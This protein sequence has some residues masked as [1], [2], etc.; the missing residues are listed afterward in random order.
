VTEIDYYDRVNPDLLRLLP[1]DVRV[2]V[3]VGCGAGAL[4]ERYKRVN[5]HGRYFGIERHAEAARLAAGRLDG[6]VCGDVEQIDFAALGLAAGTVDC[7]VYGD[8]LEHLLDPWETLRR[9][10]TWLRPEGMVLAC[11]PNVQHWTIIRALLAGSWRYANEGLL[12][13]THL[14][15]FTLEGVEHLLAAAGLVAIDVR[16]REATGLPEEAFRDFQKLMGPVIEALGLDR[17]RFTAKTAA[18]QY[19]VRAGRRDV[20]LRRVLI[21]TLRTVRE[22][23]EVRVD[24]PNAF[25]ATLPGVRAITHDDRVDYAAAFA[26]E[27]RV[28]ILQ[29]AS[30]DASTGAAVVRQ[31]VRQGYLIVVEMDDDPLRWPHYADQQFFTFRACHAIQTSTELLADYFRQ[32]NPNVA[33]FPNQIASL[34]PPRSDDPD[35]PVTLFFG[36]LNRTDDW[37]P[38]MPALNRVLSDFRGRVRAQVVHDRGFFDA[39]QTDDKAFEP[40]CAYERYHELLLG[41]D[42]ALLP[43]NPTRFNSMKSDL[44]FIQCAAHGVVTLASPT[45]YEQTLRDGETGFLYR[46]GTEFEDRLRQ[47]LAEADLRRQVADRAYQ[48]VR[49]HRMLGQHFRR[50]H[51][52]YLELRGELPRLNAELRLRVPKL[53][54]DPQEDSNAFPIT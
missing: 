24:E 52:W 33:V 47:L 10:V 27:E 1:P 15:F 20:P 7:L 36:A 6:V 21:Q 19:V 9:Q 8:V 32:F 22:A 30:L 34:P 4:G 46:S 25:C 12:D 29:R 31:W 37:Q 40:W 44:K 39:L 3:D 48:Y 5:P 28:L 50:R 13:R 18:A 23:S 54:L 17:E 41:V 11:I 42:V 51:A 45:V 43:L 14:R 2:V 38:V 53:S 49:D 35:R 16:V 26:D